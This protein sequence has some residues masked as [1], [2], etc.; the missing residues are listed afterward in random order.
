MHLSAITVYPIKS[1]RGI[2]IGRWEIDRFGFKHDRRWML[3]DAHGYFISQRT[4]R[5]LALVKVSKGPDALLVETEGMPPLEVRLNPP[6]L[7]PARVGVWRDLVEAWCP[8][9]NADAW[10]SSLLGQPLKLAYM[11]DHVVRP[12]NPEYAPNGGQA[13][14]ADAY[15]FLL[16]GEGSLTE[17]NSRLPTP[18]PM[19]RFRP[20]LVVSGSA[21]FAED[22]WRRIRIG[23]VEFDV[24]K[25]CERCVVTTTD[26][27]TAMIGKEPLRTLATFRRW[28][29]D[30]RF[31]MNV[32]HR[33]TGEVAVGD[34][35]LVS[36]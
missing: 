20:N 5:R 18:L 8:E 12:L 33:A 27:E 29:G 16:I 25:P 24:V 26:Q 22:D 35:V 30:V 36:E 6:R 9:P 2:S 1:C 34:Q 10:F 15:P 32:V 28:G 11:P 31:G 7:A 4:H 17:L 3:I 14:F 13:S 23:A 19:N 21:P